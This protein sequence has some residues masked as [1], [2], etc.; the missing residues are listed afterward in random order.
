MTEREPCERLT[1]YAAAQT[2]L[3]DWEDD[4]E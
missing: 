2:D 3:G 4:D 1:A